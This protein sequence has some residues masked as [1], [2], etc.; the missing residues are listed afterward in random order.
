[1]SMLEMEN[2]DEPAL[3]VDSVV[4]QDRCVNQLADAR[5]PRHRVSNVG[6]L[7]QQ[8][9]VIENRGSES[10][11]GAREVVPGVFENLFEIL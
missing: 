1:M 4:D 11:G 2:L 6:E 3:F 7:A 10:F 5:R 8:L 9:Q